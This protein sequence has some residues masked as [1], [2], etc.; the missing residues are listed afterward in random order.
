MSLSPGV[1][2]ERG[3]SRLSPFPPGGGV[4][5]GETEDGKGEM[6]AVPS[7][8]SQGNGELTARRRNGDSRCHVRMSQVKVLD[9]SKGALVCFN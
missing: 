5:G 1:T 9:E 8:G 6:G 7:Q 4:G 3:H 2:A